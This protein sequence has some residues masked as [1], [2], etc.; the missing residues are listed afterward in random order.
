LNYIHDTSVIDPSAK[1]TTGVQVGPLCVVGPRTSI[2]RGT[3]L[4]SNVIVGPDVQIG[5]NNVLHPFSAIGADPQD[6]SEGREFG[7]LIVGDR[8]RIREHVVIHRGL[9][10]QN[11]H[12]GDDNVVM[13]A[14][15]I[16]HNSR[17]GH[18]TSIGG[19]VVLAPNVC[20]EDG[21]S[22]GAAVIVQ[23]LVTVGSCSFLSSTIRLSKDAPPFVIMDGNPAEARSVNSIAMKMYGFDESEMDVV[24]TVFKILFR[25]GGEPMSE[26]IALL[27]ERYSHSKAALRMCRSIQASMDGSHGKAMVQR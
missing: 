27:I 10:G 3:V 4:Q 26:K 23:N 8:N 16:G 5:E 6:R 20:V 25:Q 24:K 9:G 11:T 15:N 18:K 12:I 19:Q 14:T 17:I 7:R 13:C 1:L 2:G 22:I 21:V